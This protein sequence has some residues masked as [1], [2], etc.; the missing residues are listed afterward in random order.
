MTNQRFPF[1]SKQDEIN[2][3]EMIDQN[4]EIFDH[5]T[6]QQIIAIYLNMRYSNN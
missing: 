5:L 6:D 1:L 2:I 3:Q 4:Q